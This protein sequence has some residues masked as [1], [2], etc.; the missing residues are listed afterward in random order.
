MPA[1]RS[2]ND[3]DVNAV[4]DV[5]I[6]DNA[7]LPACQAEAIRDQLKA[8][9]YTGTIDVSNNGAACTP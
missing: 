6:K 2:V 1:L 7:M 8:S 4:R 5:A 3:R 9:G